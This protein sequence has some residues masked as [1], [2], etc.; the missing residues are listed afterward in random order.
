MVN[1]YDAA[2][3]LAEDLTQT[4]QYKKLQEAIKAVEDDK[5]ASALFKKMDE[6]QNKIMQ[7]QQAGQPLSA[8]DQQAYKDLND[9]VQKNDKIVSLLTNE[10]GLYDLLGEVQKLTL[11]Q[12]MIFMKILEI[13]IRD[14]I[15]SLCGCA[16]R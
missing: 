2:N 9:Q 4:D 13:N 14:E 15:Y 8:E 1:I 10:Q 5:D 16:L 6:L 12:L 7:A 3:K 11:S